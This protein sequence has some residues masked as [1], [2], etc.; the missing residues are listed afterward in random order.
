MKVIYSNNVME[1]FY[2]YGMDARPE[3]KQSS[4]DRRVKRSGQARG[5]GLDLPRLLEKELGEAAL[6]G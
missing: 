1:R 4:A 2:V 6:Q 5:A 3:G